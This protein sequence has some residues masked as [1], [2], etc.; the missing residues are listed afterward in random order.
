MSARDAWSWQDFLACAPGWTLDA[1]G[2]PVPPRDVGAAVIPAAVVRVAPS[3]SAPASG[4][5]ETPNSAGAHEPAPAAFCGEND[6]A[7]PQL[8]RARELIA[9][10][11]H[12]NDLAGVVRLS[13]AEREQLQRE[14]RQGQARQC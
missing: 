5:P 12:P 1:M 4:H 6:N 9:Q 8:R 11:I 7:S 14:A 13:G 10:G 3:A 2:R